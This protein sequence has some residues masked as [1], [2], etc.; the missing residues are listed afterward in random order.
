MFVV[1]DFGVKGPEIFDFWAG[2]FGLLDED[3]GGGEE[4]SL[5][6]VVDRVLG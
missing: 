2:D 5:A 3:H 1:E 6:D 4:G